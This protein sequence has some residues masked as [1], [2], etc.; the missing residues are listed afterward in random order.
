MPAAAAQEPPPARDSAGPRFHKNEPQR[1][2]FAQDQ[3]QEAAYHQINEGPEEVEESREQNDQRPP[4]GC[5][6]PS[7]TSP[8]VEGAPHEV[9]AAPCAVLPA[10]NK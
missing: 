10:Q 8:Q 7:T 6:G 1:H 9:Q 2:P 4:P 5:L 3:I